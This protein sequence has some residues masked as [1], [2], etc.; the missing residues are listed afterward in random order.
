M[1]ILIDIDNTLIDFAKCSEQAIIEIFEEYD[2][3]YTPDVFSTFTR[4]NIAIWKRL[5]QGEIDKK[6]LK[7]NRWNIILGK[8]GIEADGAV[9]EELFEGKI[10]SS[11]YEVDGAEDLLNYLSR[12]YDLYVVSNGFRA[13]Q[14][15]RLSISGFD[16][17]F[18]KLFLSED[19][20]ISKPAREFFDYC[21]A[22]LGNPEKENVILIG[23]SMSADITGGN[24][25][26]IK[27][28]WFNKNNEKCP[29]NVKPD[30]IVRALS[31]ITEII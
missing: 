25:Y 16:R 9:F 13:V 18:K 7:E 6:Y 10:A 28:I 12:K 1:I 19:I 4:E 5:E 31:E 22:E 3:P 24:S 2:I 11:A 20:G 23:D 8:L 27:T 17:F 21:F 30:Y 29:D 26:G 15:N 14:E